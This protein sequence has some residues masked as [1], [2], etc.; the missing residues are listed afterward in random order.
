[1]IGLACRLLIAL[2]LVLP[3]ACSR[4]F[5]IQGIPDTFASL[6]KAVK[7]VVVN[8]FSTRVVRV[9]GSTG[10][11]EEDFFRQFFGQA[12]PYRAQRQQSLGSGF[13]FSPDGYIVTNAHVVSQA[14]QIRVRLS[15][16][17]EYDARLIGM[18]PKTDLALLKINPR[19]ELQAARLGDSESLEVGDWVIAVGNPFGFSST[20]TA[21]IVSAKDRQIGAGPYDDFIQTDAS[22]NPGNSG[23]PLLNIRGEVVGIN[24]AIYSRSGGSVGIG[25]AIPV[26]LAKK[27]VSELR[28][29]GRVVRGWLGINTQEM[30]QEVALSFGLHPPRGALVADVES[31][32]PAEE[33]GI[34][35][36]DIILAFNGS[37]IE[38][39]RHLPARIAETPVG[40]T[41]TL[42]LLRDGI[43][44]DIQVVVREQPG[45]QP[46]RVESAASL[47][48][49]GMRLTDLT[50]ELMR[51]FNIPRSVRGAMIRDIVRG[52]PASI[53]GL[54]PGDVIRQIDRRPVT[55]A[56]MAQQILDRADTRVLLLI[57]RGPASGYEAIEREGSESQK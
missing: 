8:I 41:I 21:G 43:E 22:I 44:K 10:D 37:P 1:M 23:G 6:A 55:S 5:A 46:R 45:S 24:S 12:M 25:F 11:P 47:G 7:P 31:G 20:V 56:R 51:R 40:T 9:Q 52:G 57:Q 49:W 13:V 19:H 53:S 29:R 54:Q 48:P 30:S 3:S 26:N 38:E 4:V 14:E 2:L 33:A 16:R 34:Q 35:R 15:T 39:G 42:T 17:E 36:G 32:S 50:P 18:D 27:V 28:D